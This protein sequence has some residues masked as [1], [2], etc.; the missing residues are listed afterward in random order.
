MAKIIN[1]SIRV[2]TPEE[3]H[4]ATFDHTKLSAINTCPT[5][6]ILR[7]GMHK[8]MPNSA[9]AMALDAGSA[10]HEAFAAVRIN[11]L[12][13]VQDFPILAEY[14]GIRL[15]GETRYRNG[16]DLLKTGNTDRTNSINFA[17]HMLETSGF[18]DDPQDKRRTLGNISEA[19]IAYIDRW[20]PVRYPIWIR[21]VSDME[22]DVGIEVPFDLVVDLEYAFGE[23]S[24]YPGM[25]KK[26]SFRLTGKMDGIHWDKDRLLIQENKTGARIDDAWL[27]QW[28]LSHQITGYCIAASTWTKVPCYHA[29]VIGMAIPQPRSGVENGVRYELVPRE[30]WMFEKWA[31]WLLHTIQLYEQYIDNVADAPTYTHSCNRYFRS[32]SFVPF[33][34][35]DKDEKQL[36]LQE[37]QD[38][39]WSPLHETQAD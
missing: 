31:S 6:G 3:A 4:L 35:A 11:Q 34:M 33:C 28:Q 13:A 32:C 8:Q 21:D 10:A 17:L 20:N 2:A 37:M 26:K 14:H 22:S 12:N 15:F 30:Q 23:D 18:Y 7:Y 39:E 24:E 1:V 29:Q 25:T 19:I 16:M 38:D 27:A 5:W 9:R 36:V